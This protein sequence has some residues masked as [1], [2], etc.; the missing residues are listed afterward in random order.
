[1]HCP[2]CG[3]EMAK[4]EK[5][6]RHCGHTMTAKKTSFFTPGKVKLLMVLLVIALLAGAG[7]TVF[8]GMDTDDDDGTF[9]PR[10]RTWVPMDFKFAGI[11]FE[12]PGEGWAVT[13][14]ATSRMIFR[15]TVD[16]MG[17]LDV[18]FAS[19]FVLNPDIHRV[20]NKPHIYEIVSQETV[21]L[22]GLY[23]EAT[24]TTVERM[25]DGILFRKQQLFF[26]RTFIAPNGQPQSFSY[27]VT[28]SY[29][30]VAERY[31]DIFDHILETMELYE[32]N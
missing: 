31:E 9:D 21:Q 5:T 11:K 29:P 1:M 15:N 7:A 32:Y 8:W 26:R 27:L 12:I 23:A 13:Y 28:L 10:G 24:V 2:G 3:A 17:E 18:Y 25:K 6:C 4:G 14:D 20:D 22:D 16:D 19:L 30:Q